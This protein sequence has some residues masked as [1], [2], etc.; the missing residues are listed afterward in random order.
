MFSNVVLFTV[1]VLLMVRRCVFACVV[2]TAMSVI[3][4]VLIA[5]M[6]QCDG[7]LILSDHSLG[8]AAF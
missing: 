4:I 5:V 2:F 7:Y 6:I 8:A 3:I 1:G